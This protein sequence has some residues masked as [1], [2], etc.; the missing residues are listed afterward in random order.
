MAR[1]TPGRRAMQPAGARRTGGTNVPPPLSPREA[2][3]QHRIEGNRAQVLDIAEQVFAQLGYY[4]TSIK[5]I[6]E[7]CEFS[8]GSIYGLFTDKEDLF[9]A[10]V[11]HRGQELTAVMT[12]IAQS[13]SPP[14]EK[15]V[16]MA[17]GQVSV[18]R[19]YPDWARIMTAFLAPGSRATLP[20]GRI[21]ASYD[22][23]Y[24]EAMD[25]LAGIIASGQQRGLI[26]PGSPQALAWVFA[27]L[28]SI[29]HV[30]EDEA[31]RTP[32]TFQLDELTDLIRSAFTATLPGELP[33]DL[34]PNPKAR[35]R[36]EAIPPDR[37]DFS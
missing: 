27:G 24:R 13:D 17:E 11:T 28:V 8:V 20:G 19:R 4:N 14:V 21:A 32:M 12:E 29:H 18:F 7:R 36:R 31:S 3:R 30:I 10:V 1:T 22:K 37:G 34:P 15:L 33:D 26:R 6:A 23:G 5:L 2:R 35:R 25:L 16:R 9:Q